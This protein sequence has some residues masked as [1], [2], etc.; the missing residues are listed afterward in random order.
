LSSALFHRLTDIRTHC[1][2]FCSGYGVI[3]A[4]QCHQL[5]VDRQLQ[6]QSYY[7]QWHWFLYK[8]MAVQP[9]SKPQALASIAKS[10]TTKLI[11]YLYFMLISRRLFWNAG[12]RNLQELKRNWSVQTVFMAFITHRHCEL[13]PPPPNRISTLTLNSICRKLQCWFRHFPCC[14]KEHTVSQPNAEGSWRN[15]QTSPYNTIHS[16]EYTVHIMQVQTQLV[17]RQFSD[18][19]LPNGVSNK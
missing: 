18:S 15:R 7:T 5:Q 10:A 3:T 8:P 17:H 1:H 9:A 19:L 2:Y 12:N 13:N 16:L 6:L 11:T 4:H 14:Q